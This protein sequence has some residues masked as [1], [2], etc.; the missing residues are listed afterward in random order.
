MRASLVGAAVLAL[1]EL[2]SG[3]CAS[4]QPPQ[5]SAEF[6]APRCKDLKSRPGP[7]GD[8]CR[9]ALRVAER[10]ARLGAAGYARA[11]ARLRASTKDPALRGFVMAQVLEGFWETDWLLRSPDDSYVVGQVAWMVAGDLMPEVKQAF[12]RSLH[13]QAVAPP[14]PSYSRADDFAVAIA[15]LLRPEPEAVPDLCRLIRWHYDDA[16]L[17][18]IVILGDLMPVSSDAAQCLREA[19][20]HMRPTWARRELLLALAGRAPPFAQRVLECQ[21]ALFGDCVLKQR[22]KLQD[23]TPI[24]VGFR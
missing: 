15:F 5:W 14:T 2:L 12:L 21:E 20:P 23:G 4:P 10:P 11:V 6:G 1:V 8:W 16:A 22:G 3:C 17:D 18:W 9:L 13:E 7:G 19:L 24:I